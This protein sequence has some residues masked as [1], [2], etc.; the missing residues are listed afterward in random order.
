MS[1]SVPDYALE[2]RR[3]LHQAESALEDAKSGDQVAYARTLGT[4]GVGYGL[5]AILKQLALLEPPQ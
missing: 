1:S 5:L 4:I 2:A 3:V